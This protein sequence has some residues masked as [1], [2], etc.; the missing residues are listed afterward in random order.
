MTATCPV[1][2]TIN[3]QLCVS[4]LPNCALRMR[5]CR[6]ELV[7]RVCRSCQVFEGR[8][9]DAIRQLP[10][11]QSAVGTN[12]NVYV[13]TEAFF[14]GKRSNR[15]APLVQGTDGSRFC[16]FKLRRTRVATG[17]WANH[18]CTVSRRDRIFRNSTKTIC[19]GRGRRSVRES[20]IFELSS[21]QNTAARGKVEA[22][23]KGAP[24]MRLHPRK[25]WGTQRGI[26]ADTAGKPFGSNTYDCLR[27]NC[28]T[29]RSPLAT[30]TRS[31][32]GIC[33]PAER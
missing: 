25:C 29:I 15:L 27:G 4:L 17:T 8:K 13:E 16:T 24:S 28:M 5:A 6:V 26:F 19:H 9:Y 11:T 30:K 7:H 23:P 20:G 18:V 12:G 33:T 3:P 22:V 14:P 10:A 32:A 31:R 2:Q 1:L 21:V